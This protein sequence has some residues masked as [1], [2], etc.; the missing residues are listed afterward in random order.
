[1]NY[2]QAVDKIRSLLL[3]NRTHMLD[4]VVQFL[5]EQFEHYHWIGIYIVKDEMLHLGPW[6]GDHATEHIKIAIGKGICG[7]A[8]QTGKT[9]IIPD[10]NQDNR[11]LA[12]FRSTRAEIVVPI[13]YKGRIIAEI[14]IDSD[15]PHV[16]TID[17]KLFL[18]KV[19][20]MLAPH[21]CEQ[22]NP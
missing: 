18:E 4:Q 13:R 7:A 3:T 14:D 20:D 2:T 22:M 1:M 21:I 12:C 11:Y 19:A 15:T 10:V 8:A 17:D 16:F 5:Y 9:E 6:R